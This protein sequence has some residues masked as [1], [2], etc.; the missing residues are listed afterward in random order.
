MGARRGRGDGPGGRGGGGAPLG[1]VVAT[2]SRAEVAR[3]HPAVPA[4]GAPRLGVHVS[5][6]DANLGGV[7]VLEIAEDVKGQRSAPLIGREAELA[8]GRAPRIPA[9]SSPARATGQPLLP[10]A[11]G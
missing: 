1:I 7:R 11:R 3:R 2:V 9:G 10:P 4:H 6:L 8:E 5:E